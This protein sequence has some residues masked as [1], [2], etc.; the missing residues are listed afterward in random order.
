MASNL[1][2]R[3]DQNNKDVT[4]VQ[5]N[6]ATGTKNFPGLGSFKQLDRANNALFNE[7]SRKIKLP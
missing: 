7:I 2:E 3:D 6:T 1:T 5:S 4:K